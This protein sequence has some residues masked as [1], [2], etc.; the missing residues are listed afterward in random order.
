MIYKSLATIFALAVV[1]PLTGFLLK[2]YVFISNFPY[3]NYHSSAVIISLII[4]RLFFVVGVFG[5][6]LGLAFPKLA[7]FGKASRK[8]V[9]M[10][11]LPIFLFGFVSH[12]ESVLLNKI[13][14]KTEEAKLSAV[15]QHLSS[16]LS[17]DEIIGLFQDIDANI[18]YN[19]QDN[20][21]FNRILGYPY[22]GIPTPVIQINYPG[23]D[24]QELII[25][26]MS[27]RP[28]EKNAF[29][30]MIVHIKNDEV[31]NVRPSISESDPQIFYGVLEIGSDRKT[32]T[33][34]NGD[35]PL[36]IDFSEIREENFLERYTRYADAPYQRRYSIVS[37]SIEVL[38]Q[39][40]S[41]SRIFKLFKVILH[42]PEKNYS[43]Y[44]CKE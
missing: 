21:E 18:S 16:E 7:A 23:L 35:V 14:S 1:L 2:D 31:V 42:G 39:A 25:V 29:S 41:S 10:I 28:N 3:G 9:I 4:S 8:K 6:I 36:N 30:Q 19:Y 22:D 24:P 33:P 34:C 15:F 44:K 13:V 12:Y 27:K 38:G 17:T 20:T 37:G 43:P 5:L 11:Y 40:T 32:F 26:E